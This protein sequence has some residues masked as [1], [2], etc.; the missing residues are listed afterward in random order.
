MAA[1]T[2]LGDRIRTLRETAG[3]T[4][5]A[6]DVL[7]GLTPGHITQYENG[8]L[9]G[10]RMSAATALKICAVFGC[11]VEWL[12]SG[13]GEPPQLS[14]VAARVAGLRDELDSEPAAKAS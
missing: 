6:F 1:T 9:S 7:A 12:M 5:R 3:L 8:I 13:E 14:G 10:E 11:S 2:A 4:T